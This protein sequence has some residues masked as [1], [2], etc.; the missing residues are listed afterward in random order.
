MSLQRER[1]SS[2]QWFTV[3]SA[4]KGFT[5][6]EARSAF[7]VEQAARPQHCPLSRFFILI[8]ML[9]VFPWGW[10]YGIVGGAIACNNGI[11]YG[12]PFIMSWLATYFHAGILGKA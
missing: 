9:R 7:P 8:I 4:A 1:E 12:C 10:C 11:P 2:T 6:T 5:L 3:E